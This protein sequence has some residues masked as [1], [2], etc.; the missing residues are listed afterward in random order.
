MENSTG[1]TEKPYPAEITPEQETTDGNR[2]LDPGKNCVYIFFKARVVT[3][4]RL[5]ISQIDPT[6]VLKKT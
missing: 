1:G 4:G 6:A 5:L 3:V 2:P